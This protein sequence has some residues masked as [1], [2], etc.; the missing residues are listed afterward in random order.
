MSKL[1]AEQAATFPDNSGATNFLSLANDGDQAIV[2][3][4]YNSILDIPIYLI[5]E[6]PGED[7]RNKNV[8]CLRSSYDQPDSVCP[9]CA[10]GYMTK[11]SIYFNVRNEQT[12]EM[13]LWQ[14]TEA[15][16]RRNV[17]PI[18]QEYEESGTPICSIPFKIKRN[19][20]KGDTRTTYTLIPLPSDT[21]TLDDFPED[22][23]VEETGIVKEFDFNVLQS[24]ANTGIV[25]NNNNNNQQQGVTRR[26]NDQS[27]GQPARVEN[28]SQPAP[29]AAPGNR[30]RRTIMNNNNGGY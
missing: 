17:L 6:I 14:K 3:F 22:I 1:S 25:P 13:Q 16:F 2:R 30:N 4:A 8:G 11:K 7:G 27:F 28:Y 5:H 24:I 9:L 18:L 15:F 23:I 26:G 10:A 20:A 12:G 21:T 29:A 19:G